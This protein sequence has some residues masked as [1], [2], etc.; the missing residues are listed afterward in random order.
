[1]PC[2]SN[3]DWS[4]QDITLEMTYQVFHFIDWR[5][6]RWIAKHPDD[7]CELNPILGK[8]PST[9]EVDL[10]FIGTA[11]LHPLITDLLPEKYRPIWQG[12]T[13]GMSATCVGWNFS[14]GIGFDF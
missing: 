7:Y 10:Y 13:I 9:T 2:I 11:L 6:T 4:E 8:H 12:I 5:Q 1:M 3:A 14:L